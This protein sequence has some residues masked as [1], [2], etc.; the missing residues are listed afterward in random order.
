[1]TKKKPESEKKKR[2]RKTIFTP[3]LLQKLEQGF[4]IG[5]TDEECCAYVEINMS[6]FYEWQKK[7]PD[8][9]YKKQQWKQ[10]PIA[11]AKNTIFN[12]LDDPQTAKWYL[13]RKCNAEFSTKQI[14]DNTNVNLN[15]NSENKT[16]YD[17]LMNYL[18]NWQG[19]KK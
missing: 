5:L 11:K 7:H 4:K 13:E 6:T 18:N 15:F 2:G 1:M 9:L 14:N 19:F 16:E 8:F 3:E 10:N 12:S 17:E